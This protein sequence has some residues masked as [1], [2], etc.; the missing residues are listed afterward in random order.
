[1][2][3]EESCDTEQSRSLN[4]V[5]YSLSLTDGQQSR[6]PNHYLELDETQEDDC[7]TILEQPKAQDL[8]ISSDV[9]A[10]SDYLNFK[11]KDGKQLLTRELA[12]VKLTERTRYEIMQENGQRRFGPPPEWIGPPPGR[13]CEI[14]IGKIPRDCFEDELV[15]I[16]EKAGKIYMFRLMMDFSGCNRGYGF[17]IY[18][19]REDSKRAVLELDNYEIRKGRI[20]GV[21]QSLDNCRLFVGGIPKNRSKYEIFEEMEK[22]TDGVKDV[23]VFTCPID[24]TKNRGFAFVEYESHKAAAMARRKLIP[25]RCQLFG[26]QIAVDWAEP[27]REIDNETMS[28]VRV[29]YVRGL[30]SSISEERLKNH[31]IAALRHCCAVSDSL[32]FTDPDTEPSQIERVKKIRNYAF[33]HFKDRK[34]AALLFKMLNGT[35]LDGSRLEISWAKPSDRF[36][37]SKLQ[38]SY[39]ANEG[40]DK[41]NPC[42][43]NTINFSSQFNNNSLFRPLAS[44]FGRLKPDLYDFNNFATERC[45]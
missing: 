12:L 33:I 9:E 17:C 28:K 2:I 1:M 21:C 45:E 15:P 5:N 30:L 14:F 19:N 31:F 7:F 11:A 18:T 36:T 41:E 4:S 16:F 26:H 23:I 34:I 40:L 13:G 22:I 39:T 35:L 25:S 44:T 32:V 6:A 43:G 27:E 37:T 24:K 10:T 42:Y 20:L 3:N 8:D 29:L 38:L